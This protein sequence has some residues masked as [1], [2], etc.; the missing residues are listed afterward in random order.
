MSLSYTLSLLLLLLLSLLPSSLSLRSVGTYIDPSATFVYLTKFSFTMHSGNLTTHTASLLPANVSSQALLLYPDTPHLWSTVMSSSTSCGDKLSLGQGEWVYQGDLDVAILG[1]RP[2]YWLIAALNCGPGGIALSYDLHM[3]NGGDAWTR[4]VSY[5]QWGIAQT[6]I[7]YFL[8]YLLALPLAAYLTHRHKSTL[9][10]TPFAILTITIALLLLA[11][12]LTLAEYGH[13]MATGYQRTSLGDASYWFTAF[14]SLL[15][16][17]SVFVTAT[18][19]PATRPGRPF[20][21]AL[22][23]LISVFFILYIASFVVHQNE[24][25]WRLNYQYDN[26]PGYL[27]AI[28]YGLSP[29]PLALIARRSGRYRYA[30]GGAV[31]LAAFPFIVLGA[32][33]AEP[34]WVAKAAWAAQGAVLVV[35]VLGQLAYLAWV[36]K[37]WWGEPGKEGEAVSAEG[38]DKRG[39]SSAEPSQVHLELGEMQDTTEGTGEG[40][41]EGAVVP[42]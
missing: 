37:G 12:L 2:H 24:A 40:G 3:T 14:A 13:L 35:A 15:L 28:L 30:V 29:L 20:A 27:L 1:Q 4:E 17:P 21:P 31:Y 34:Y 10:S 6:A 9:L 19:Y 25:A 16:I 26:A 32:S 41:A 36:S 33:L 22:S 8:I 39:T 7:A 23:V 5:D 38:R 42:I 11:C 18:G